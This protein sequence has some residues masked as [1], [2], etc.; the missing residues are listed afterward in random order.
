MDKVPVAIAVT[1]RGL[2]LCAPL[3]FGVRRYGAVYRLRH[4][5][6]VLRRAGVL[7]ALYFPSPWPA[8]WRAF[9]ARLAA[10]ALLAGYSIDCGCDYTGHNCFS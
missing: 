5:R 1:L 8:A 2:R 3:N 6:R 4:R 7:H 10:R 9:P